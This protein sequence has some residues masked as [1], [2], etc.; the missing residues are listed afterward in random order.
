MLFLQKGEVG[1][2]PAKKHMLKKK[3]IIICMVFCLILQLFSFNVVHAASSNPVK[4]SA[5]TLTLTIG[6]TY[7]IKLL[8]YSSESVKWSTSSKSKATVKK[9]SSNSATITAKKKGTVKI[10]AKAGKKTYT[11]IVK[12]V[13]KKAYLSKMSLTMYVGDTY[14]L[15]LMNN[16]KSV[17]W[18]TSSKS[19]ASIKKLSKN[20]VR[21]TA[22]K[23]GTAKI[24]AKV[25]SKT[26][27]CVVKV[28]DR[29]KTKSINL[30]YKGS[31]VEGNKV[32]VISSISPSNATNKSVTW[33]SSNTSIAIVDQNGWVTLKKAGY[34]KIT[35]NAK[36]GASSKTITLIIVPKPVSTPDQTKTVAPTKPVPPQTEA[37]KKDETVTT[38]PTT[39]KVTQSTEKETDETL[40]PETIPTE[41]EKDTSEE[42]NIPKT[43]GVSESKTETESESDFFVTEEEI[44]DE[45]VRW[46]PLMV[47][48]TP[49]KVLKTSGST[50]SL[51]GKQDPTEL[52]WTTSDPKI[53]TVD[54]NGMVSCVGKGVVTI[55]CTSKD[56]KS[57]YTT[58]F[59]VYENYA[60][61][62]PDEWK[63]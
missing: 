24:K 7:N 58:S 45:I 40:K 9:V 39:E 52:I 12:V 10:K 49:T 13:E 23:K 14:D 46:D 60:R 44:V 42:I 31:L 3:S 38:K 63:D 48:R 8:N 61:E 59:T 47:G 19:K 56:G 5:K 54:E 11:C 15:E 36:D 29:I 28:Q 62:L 50:F 34:V 43:E 4:L 57:G 17:K 26:Y 16:S 21:I 37:V 27:T 18:S 33:S 25:G 53:A 35:C 41:T 6:D 1:I 30:T 2:I 55:T 32:Q 22:K 51:A 20:K